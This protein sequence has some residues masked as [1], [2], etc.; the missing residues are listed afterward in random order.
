MTVQNADVARLFYR[1]AEL[2]EI[3]G[4]NSF[5]VRAYRRAAAL[6]ETLPDEVADRIA[7]GQDLADLPAIGEDLAAK[8][9]EICRTGR[10]SALDEVERNTPA[11]LTAL[12]ALPG[13]GPKR[14]AALHAHLGVTSPH[15]LQR[16]AAAGRVA[17]LPGFGA[18]LQARLLSALRAVPAARPS[19]VPLAIAEAVARPLRRRLT[20]GLGVTAVTVAGSVRR[21]RETVGDLD[22]LVVGADHQAII[23]RFV[24]YEEVAQV[25]ARGVTRAAVVLNGGL[26][27]DLRAVDP[28]SQGAAL[29]YFT[30]SKAH[31][32]ALRRLAQQ[33]GLKINEYGV[34]RG[35]RKVA[36][37][38][39]EDVYAS[40]GLPWIAPELR[41]DRGELAAA[42]AGRLPVLVA[43]SDIRGDLHVRP[44]VS[45]GKTGLERMARAARARGYAYIAISD[46]AGRSAGPQGLDEKGL[47]RRIDD[48]DRLNAQLGGVLV[49]KACEVDILADGR[50]DLPDTVLGRLDLVIGA[51]RSDL[52]LPEDV[53]TER[54]IRAMD[55]PCFNIL[56]HPVVRRVGAPGG[57]GLDLPRTMAA[58]RARGCFLEL[59][60]DPGRLELDDIQCRAAGAAGVKL[61]IGS[62]ARSTAGLDAMRHGVD[63]ARRGWL[64]P[65]DVLNTYAWPDLKALLTR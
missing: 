50:L 15:A 47:S 2:L 27:V 17:P 4:A 7:R 21:R 52:G 14:I 61:A 43:L 26:Q 6:I 31:V 55:H 20:A 39:E 45:G 19:R 41:E 49:L 62:N 5:R 34:F 37:R 44:S 51:V 65:G 9:G 12:A 30:G 59:N 40:V 3:Q 64:G 22:I 29:L 35:A 57:Y 53:Q 36:G 24:A 32:V 10:L 25:L 16:A 13:L 48:I 46:R 8:I 1:M 28:E 58:A 23:D 60:A 33:R 42:A 63:Q 38:T 54:V 18:K 11:G 56:A